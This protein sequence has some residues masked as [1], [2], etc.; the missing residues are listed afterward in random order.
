MVF[1]LFKGPE[2]QLSLFILAPF[3]QAKLLEEV[4]VE[5]PC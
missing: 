1:L 4:E 5:L 2:A 3:E